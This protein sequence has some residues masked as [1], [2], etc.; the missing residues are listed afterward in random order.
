MALIKC[1]CI[2][3]KPKTSAENVHRCTAAKSG[4]AGD[5]H[6][7]HATRQVSLL[8]M[9]QVQDYFSK[10]GEPIRYGQFG[11]NLVVEGLDWDSLQKGDLLRAG[12]V[13]LEITRIGAG[14]PK[15]AAYKGDKIC[16]PMEQ[17]YVFCKILEEGTLEENM[18][19]TKETK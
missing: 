8:P 19:I 12:T 1:V 11:E 5:I 15:S 10:R 18:E 3:T 9:N 14:G 17:L 16:A 6:F 2:D 7:G 13:V 4:L